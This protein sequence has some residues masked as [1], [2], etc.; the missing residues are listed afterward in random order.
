MTPSHS[1][2]R[3]NGRGA[4]GEVI[5]GSAWYG[6]GSRVAR[7]R[8]PALCSARPREGRPM[9]L[10]AWMVLSLPHPTAPVAAQ[11]PQITIVQ[12]AEATTMDPGRSPQVLTATYFFNLYASLTRRAPP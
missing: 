2:G 8:R 12:P 9:T 10:F 11:P 4:G 1:L 6:G 5:I 7:E 3:A